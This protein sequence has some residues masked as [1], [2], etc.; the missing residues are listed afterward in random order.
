MRWYYEVYWGIVSVRVL[1]DFKCETWVWRIS[2]NIL[3]CLRRSGEMA[4]KCYETYVEKRM[5]FWY[6]GCQNLTFEENTSLDNVEMMFEKPAGSEK[7]FENPSGAKEVAVLS[8]G[9]IWE[10]CPKKWFE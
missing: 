1:I 2:K 8:I 4:S 3:D 10:L 9:L 5:I 6:K 7:C